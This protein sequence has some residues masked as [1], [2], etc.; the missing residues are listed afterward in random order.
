M[1]A[2]S[3]F[4]ENAV[5]DQVLRGVAYPGG[6]T[7]WAAL[8]TAPTVDST[9]AQGEVVGGN[10]ARVQVPTWD[11]AA[12]GQTSNSVPVSFNAAT[13]PWGT[14]THFALFDDQVTG[15][16][17]YHGPLTVPRTVNAGDTFVFP[18]GNITISHD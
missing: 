13:F 1:T 9:V 8:F 7:I 18:A 17:L 6:T 14:V 4:L 2:M 16:L 11:P 3:D 15:N 12:S 5:L 10:Y